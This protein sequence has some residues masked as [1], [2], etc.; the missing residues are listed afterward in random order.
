MGW[1]VLAS[2]ATAVAIVSLTYLYSGVDADSVP[3]KWSTP[4]PQPPRDAP[5]AAV[6][7]PYT[8]SS[9][10]GAVIQMDASHHLSDG[11][12]TNS[13]L[14]AVDI[15]GQGPVPFSVARWNPGDLSPRLGPRRP[16]SQPNL[17]ILMEMRGF[18]TDDPEN[19]A[20]QAWSPSIN[21]GVMMAS[22]ALNGQQ[23][24]RSKPVFY[25]TVACATSSRAYGYN[26][27]DGTFTNKEPNLD[28]TVGQAGAEEEGSIDVAI[29]WFP[30]YQGWIGGYLNA[31]DPPA[32]RPSSRSSWTSWGSFSSALPA[33]AN[34]VLSWQ[35]MG[36]TLRLPHTHP[37]QGMLFLL[38]SYSGPENNDLNIMSTYPTSDGAWWVQVRKDSTDSADDLAPPSQA[39]F[40]FV[41]IPYNAA[42]LIGAHIEGRSGTPIIGVGQFRS[43]R[44]GPGRYE[45]HVV[46]MGR[47]YAEAEPIT[48]KDGALLL[49][50]MSHDTANHEHAQHAFLSYDIAANGSIYVEARSMRKGG[51]GEELF[52]LVDTDFAF[53]WIDFRNPITPNPLTFTGRLPQMIQET[54]FWSGLFVT[55]FVY[56]LLLLAGG[57][58]LLYTTRLRRTAA[59]AFERLSTTDSLP[60]HFPLGETASETR[61]G[62]AGSAGGAR[63]G[64]DS[65]EDDSITGA[66]LG[67]Q[68]QQQQQQQ[69]QEHGGGASQPLSPLLE[70]DE[71]DSAEEREQG[72]T[73]SG[74]TSA[75]MAPA[76]SAAGSAKGTN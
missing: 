33:D 31:P 54:D 75:A 41:Y 1:S 45:L 24:N 42:G 40:A 4:T 38:N 39:S 72:K 48:H 55:V 12:T 63:E 30:Y 46:P 35:H 5:H 50:V 76:P 21:M 23:W 47:H 20:V 3:R 68:E 44:L 56:S 17:A 43:W 52:Y 51:N 62:L 15:K 65:S 34:E 70:L 36:A 2:V 9:V 58:Y 26:M 22:V 74:A 28:I 7:P 11:S 27:D 57:L 29:A 18:D 13:N 19:A 69:Q 10:T 32:Y 61:R 49:Q 37:S 8:A 6:P 59:L 71:D 25:G 60:S 73:G 64:V 14:L 67:G 66:L 53:A 16:Y